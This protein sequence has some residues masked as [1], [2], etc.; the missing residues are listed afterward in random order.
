M[1]SDIRLFTGID[2]VAA[3]KITAGLIADNCERCPAIAERRSKG[4]DPE[5]LHIFARDADGELVGGVVAQVWRSWRWL[6]IDVI[7]VDRAHR[8][9]GI[10]HALVMAVEEEGRARGCT[11]S[12]LSTANYQAPDFYLQLGYVE[13]GRLEGFPP[14][15]TDFLMRKRL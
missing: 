10:G 3:N 9:Q 8:N 15:A 4:N 5:P 13:Y 1:G 11:D 14:G 7:W 6:Q 12:R 2:D